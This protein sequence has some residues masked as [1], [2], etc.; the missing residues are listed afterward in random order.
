MRI[1][2]HHVGQALFNYATRLLNTDAAATEETTARVE[3]DLMQV[4]QLEDDV[5]VGDQDWVF[6]QQTRRQEQ[7]GHFGYTVESWCEAVRRSQHTKERTFVVV[8]MFAGERRSGDI[9]EFLEQMMKDAG[10]TLLMLSVDLAEDPLW[11]FRRPSTVHAMMELAEEGLIDVW[12]GGPPCST[13]AR[14]RHVP[15]QGGPRP[16]RFRWALWGRGDLRPYEKERVEEANELWINFWMMC[17][18]VSARGGAYLMEH[19]ADPG[20][21]P[22]PSMWL[23]TELVE[24]EKRA[25]ATRVHFHQCPFGGISP[26]MTTF[27]GNVLGMDAVNGVKCPGEPPTHVHGKSIGRAPDGSFYTRRL[28]T[29]P[30]A[31]CRE[32]ALMIFKTLQQMNEGHTGPTGALTTDDDL[33]APRVTAWSSWGNSIRPGVVLLNEAVSRCQS[34]VI[35][36]MQSAAYVHVDDT[37]FLSGGQ[38]NF[39][40]SDVLLEKTVDGLESVGFGVTQQVKSAEIEKVVG[41]EVVS[42]P[43]QFRLPLRKMVLLRQS[44][45][46][47]AGQSKV[48]VDTL[49]SLVGMWIFGS[50]LRRELLS[51][52]HSIFHFMEEFDGDVVP[53][54]ESARCEAR[55]MARLTPLMVLHL[56]SP[57]LPMM[58]GTDAMGSTETDWGG[59]GIVASELQEEEMKVLLKVGELPGRSIAR[60]DGLNGTKFPDR[61]LVP[62][63]PFSRLPDQFFTADRWTAVE[64]GRWRYGDHITLGEARTVLKLLQRLAAWPGVHGSAVFSLQ[65]NQPTACSMAKGRSPSYSL[66]RILRQRAAVCL[67]AR[68]RLFL[69]WTE[70][71]KQPADELSRQ[72]E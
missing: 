24:M 70:S 12:L 41:Y 21:D 40:H 66:N 38:K 31:L 71:A 64:R 54:W 9:Q 37:V 51:V 23:I 15:M 16:L 32:M 4:G 33:P 14:S 3:D 18:T 2:L 7:D 44:L 56:G 46:E 19:P 61:P 48:S 26:K 22:Y 57:I 42:T 6:R 29:Y 53:W 43:A 30:A 5:S 45:L 47:M 65:D 20:M 67:S 17:D 49:R 63:V 72:F 55:A 68:L 1:N 25:N 34:L 62:T 35:G 36:D 10:L 39:L 27:S 50:L 58:F 11:D 69:P 13:V 8:H 28:Q 60:L 59:Y 52:P